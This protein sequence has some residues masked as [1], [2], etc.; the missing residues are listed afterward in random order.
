MDAALRKTLFWDY[1]TEAIEA[2]PEV[3]RAQ[4]FV[5]MWPILVDAWR[6]SG[7]LARP[8]LEAILRLIKSR[9]VELTFCEPVREAVIR[10][11]IE[12]WKI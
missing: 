6:K 8:E 11:L 9:W 5:D 4:R 3:T 1:T 2:I 10:G 7:T 12:R